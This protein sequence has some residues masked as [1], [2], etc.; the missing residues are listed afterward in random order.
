MIPVAFVGGSMRQV[1]RHA[2]AVREF[3]RFY[4]RRIGVLG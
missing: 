4:T 1:E 2:E 3:N